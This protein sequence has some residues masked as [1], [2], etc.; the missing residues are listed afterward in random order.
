MLGLRY[1]DLDVQTLL[2]IGFAII[3]VRL[4]WHADSTWMGRAVALALT[5]IM[6]L[7]AW[8]SPVAPESLRWPL[9]LVLLAA[10]VCGAPIFCIL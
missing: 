3:A 1:S 9:L 10:T 4:L 5:G 6:L 2:V 7:A 8:W